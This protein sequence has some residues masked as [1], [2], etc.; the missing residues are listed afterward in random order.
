M[1]RLFG[2]LTVALV[3]AGCG[4][5]ST[6]NKPTEPA[7]NNSSGNPITAPVDYIGAVGKGKTTADKVADLATLQKAIQ[8]FHAEEDRYPKDLNELVS[9]KILP[10]LPEPPY[11]MKFQ[12]DAASGKV[13]VVAAQ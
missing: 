13:K 1:K 5:S 3:V 10:K 11:N 6:A 8:A 2:A 4:D 12:Y 9:S 7:T